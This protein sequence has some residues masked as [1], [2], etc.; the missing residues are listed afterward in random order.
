MKI[1]R[2]LTVGALGSLPVYLLSRDP[3]VASGYFLA[4]S[5]IDLD[6]LF[7][8]WYDF[9]FN[10]DLKKFYNTCG[11]AGFNH[12]FLWLHSYDFIFLLSFLLY[13]CS[14]TKIFPYIL[15]IYLGISCHLLCDIYHNRKGIKIIDYFLLSRYR[16]R[17]KFNRIVQVWTI[18]N[19]Y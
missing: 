16:K 6:H 17:F 8:F 7:D 5:L 9:G 2:H 13:F 18:N 15:G 3:V 14:N 1:T 10:L 4:N 19:I 11:Q 12:L